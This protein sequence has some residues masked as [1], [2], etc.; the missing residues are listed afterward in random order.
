MICIAL[1]IGVHLFL[2]TAIGYTHIFYVLLVLAAVWYYQ[3]ALY[4]AGALVAA[5]LATSLFV[6]DFTWATL[7]RA[8]MFLI[9]TWI[10]AQISEERDRAKA[11]IL[12][13]K[14]AIEEKHY[15]LVGYL[16][17]VALRMKN[18]IQILHDNMAALL[19]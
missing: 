19:L 5:T 18:P 15:V 14:S 1:E 16:A 9:V 11:E 13:Q 8:A 4:V 2:R 17:E 10:V 6:G 3:K 12:V 7:L